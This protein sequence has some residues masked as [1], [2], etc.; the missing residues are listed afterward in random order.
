MTLLGVT[1]GIGSGK[2]AFVARLA[3]R[4]GVRVVR[5]DD[6]AKRLMAEDPGVRRQLVGRF[7]AS[8]FTPDGALD[9]AGLAARVFSDDAELEALNAIVHPAVGRALEAEAARARAEGL[10]VLVYESALLFET[11]SDRAVDRTVLIDAPVEVRVA[12]AAARDGV[13]EAAVRARMRHQI[14]PAEARA[15][16]DLVVDN[17]GD[18]EALHAAADRL[19]DELGV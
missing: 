11:G 14:D 9:R 2:S 17:A 8:T 3:G 10:E 4:D 18:L 6:L 7:G 16:A 15:R 12:R 1:G 13:P 19:A 5:A